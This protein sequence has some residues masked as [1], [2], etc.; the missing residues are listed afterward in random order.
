MSRLARAA[1]A[2]FPE[3]PFFALAVV[4]TA[5]R[6]DAAAQDLQMRHWS[7]R[8]AAVCGQEPP[9]PFPARTPGTR[10]RVAYIAATARPA[11]LLPLLS[12]H[13]PDRVELHVYLPDA[14]AAPPA[15]Q[16]LALVHPLEPA[17]L[18]ASC[19]TN[20]I[21]VAVDLGGL[22]LLPDQTALLRQMRR[23]IAPWQVGI[24]ASSPMDSKLS[25]S[26]DSLLYTPADNRPFPPADSGRQAPMDSKL[27]TPIDSKLYDELVSPDAA[28]LRAAEARWLADR[29]ALAALWALPSPK[30]RSRALADRALRHWLAGDGRLHL[31]TSERPDVSVVI[32]LYNQAGLTLGCLLSLADQRPGQFET[33]LIDNA[34]SDLTA[35]LLDRTE[36]ATIVR[37]PDNRGFLAAANQGAAL[38]KGRHILFLNNDT[39]L[40]EGAIARALA[41]MDGDPGAG[42]VGGR[43]IL[44]D[45]TVQ[46]AGC[47]V[48]RE[49][50]TAGYGRGL[51]PDHPHL[52]HARPV[53]Y[54]SGAFMLVRGSLWRALGGFDPAYLPA[55]YEDADFC[56]RA[57]AGGFRTLYDPGVVVSHLEWG[58]A[59]EGQA[60]SLMA[61][62]RHT[63]VARHAAALARKSAAGATDPL[64]NRAAGNRQRLLILGSTLPAADSTHPLQLIL[65][66]PDTLDI[67]YL[68]LD[69]ADVSPAEISAAVPDHIEC[70]TDIGSDG[71]EAFLHSRSGHYPHLL[72]AD[73]SAL[74]CLLNLR[75]YR[76]DL[77]SG[78]RLSCLLADWAETQSRQEPRRSFREI[79]QAVRTGI[80]LAAQADRLWVS[81]ERDRKRLAA[82]GLSS[83]RLLP[84]AGHS[85]SD[86]S[87]QL[88]A[89]L[90]DFD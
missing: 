48:F 51:P 70:L 29:E 54:V 33:I 49:G 47:M 64:R 65:R 75:L 61:T 22:S 80:A 56:L 72:A 16:A 50:E 18:G 37:N 86:F 58:S 19:L 9:R 1:L 85:A 90:T 7:R 76:P 11:E 66:T 5:D 28:A 42:I 45:G 79:R 17:S 13:D 82:R 23:R 41:R 55:Y 15:L 81:R 59:A 78:I 89:S 84:Q 24:A 83:A 44:A 26:I 69:R 20:G 73:L 60:V 12:A 68:P 52:R 74:S 34:S 40:H 77:F 87:Q 46:E 3:D 21:E 10:L 88:A 2:D 38:A 30:A 67:G 14:D 27:Y 8:H 31:P 35:D 6:D 53:D 63:L 25:T 71:L 36:G 62:N 32:I 57:A 39:I 4:L 43:I